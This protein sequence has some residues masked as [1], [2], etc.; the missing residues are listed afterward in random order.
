[1]RVHMHMHMHMHMHL[2]APLAYTLLP[3]LMPTPA[4]LARYAHEAC[5]RY[6]C[7]PPLLRPT[8]R[9]GL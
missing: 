8:Q 3:G 4:A 1:M 6:G 2:C 7:S 5:T 9:K